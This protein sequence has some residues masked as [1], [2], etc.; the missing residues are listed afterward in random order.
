MGG[1]IPAVSDTD[2]DAQVLQASQPVL[3]DF[4]AAWCAPCRM[5]AP[6]VEAIA[7]ELGQQVKVLKMDIDANPATP[8]RLGIMSIPTLIIFKDGQPADRTVGYRSN[9]KGDLMQKLEA[10][11]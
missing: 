7:S 9:L 1:H 10:L 11:L 5:I 3:V 4:W 8:G 6:V 2:F